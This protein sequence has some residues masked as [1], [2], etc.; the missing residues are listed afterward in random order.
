LVACRYKSTAGR[1]NDNAADRGLGITCPVTQAPMAVAGNGGLGM[2]GGVY[3][4]AA[5]I[6]R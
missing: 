4:D 1:C 2:I 5:W 6:G 3:G